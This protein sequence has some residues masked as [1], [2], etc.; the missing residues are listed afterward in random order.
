MN[1]LDTSGS[2]RQQTM[3]CLAK[4]FCSGNTRCVLQSLTVGLKFIIYSLII[5]PT[6]TTKEA[7]DDHDDGDC[8][9]YEKDNDKAES[10]QSTNQPTNQSIQHT[11]KQIYSYTHEPTDVMMI[12]ALP[13]G[14]V[15]VTGKTLPCGLA[16]ATRTVSPGETIAVT[17]MPPP[18]SA[19]TFSKRAALATTHLSTSPRNDHLLPKIGAKLHNWKSEVPQALSVSGLDLENFRSEEVLFASNA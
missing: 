12:L 2:I 15:Q 19:T 7:I 3:R 6:S 8:K 9:E 18:S 1:D 16:K 5:W 4:M 10:N 11:I 13:F 17:R 14:A